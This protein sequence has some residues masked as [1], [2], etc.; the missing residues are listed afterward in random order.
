MEGDSVRALGDRTLVDLWIEG[1]TRAISISRGA[2]ES[3]LR[4]MPHEA[5]A[6]T[7]TDR[8]EFVRTHL[9]IIASAATARL[10]TDPDADSILIDTGQLGGEPKAAHADRRKG[11]RRM[12]DRR[13]QNLGP[14]GGL[15]RR[16]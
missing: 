15:E 3:C 10:R 11:D 4:L 6:M 13:K 5:A 2:I 14:P 9:A 16:R 12:G 8:R 7:E 1:K